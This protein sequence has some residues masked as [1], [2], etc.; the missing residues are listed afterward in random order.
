MP[1]FWRALVRVFF[2]HMGPGFAKNL[3]YCNN[4][5]KLRPSYLESDEV[6]L[7]SNV[8]IYSYKDINLISPDF[9]CIELWFC[10]RDSEGSLIIALLHYANDVLRYV[11]I[12]FSS[13]CWSLIWVI[14]CVYI[15]CETPYQLISIHYWIGCKLNLNE[16]YTSYNDKGDVSKHGI[17]LYPIC[18]HKIFF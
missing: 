9:L 18:T 8:L 15:G 13:F 1:L 12:A 17:P 14:L 6:N 3:S 11:C 16:V 7:F 10:L 5:N 2:F 4:N